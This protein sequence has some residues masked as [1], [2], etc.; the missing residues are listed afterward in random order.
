MRYLEI[1]RN[2]F[3]LH[4][5]IAAEEEEVKS[6]GCGFAVVARN[7]SQTQRKITRRGC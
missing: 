4:S 3:I 1:P 7:S 5:L 6:S 2:L